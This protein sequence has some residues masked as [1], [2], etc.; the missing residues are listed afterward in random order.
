[1]DEIAVLYFTLSGKTY[2]IKV[3]ETS[4]MLERQAPTHG[5][6]ASYRRGDIFDDATSTWNMDAI[7]PLVAVYEQ[8]RKQSNTKG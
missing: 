2:R 8:D 4:I 1:M 7:I 6:N 3:F 5:E